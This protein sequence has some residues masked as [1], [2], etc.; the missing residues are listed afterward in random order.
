[1]MKLNM[2]GE[3]VL[4]SHDSEAHRRGVGRE[5]N[6]FLLGFPLIVHV[7]LVVLS[8]FGSVF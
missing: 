6:I 7:F 3:G 4:L 1:M 8:H 5:V 2:S